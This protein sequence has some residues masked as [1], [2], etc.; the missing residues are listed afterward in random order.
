MKPGQ[1]EPTNVVGLVVR[2]GVGK[3]TLVNKWLDGLKAEQLAERT[4]VPGWSFFS[5]QTGERVTSGRSV[6][7]PRASRFFND[8]EPE[9]GSPWAKG[10]R[11]ADLAR[12]NRALLILDGLEPLQDRYQ[13]IK[14]PALQR[15][16]E[17]FAQDNSG[18]VV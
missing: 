11:L 6:H 4:R 15:L 14:D 9:A 13:G 2:G 3:S 5:Q 1:V 7:R 16:I 17:E 10:E 18:T 8:P 12:K